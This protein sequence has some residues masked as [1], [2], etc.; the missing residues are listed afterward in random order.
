VVISGRPADP[1]ICRDAL[2]ASSCDL[3]FLP[4][5]TPGE[6]IGFAFASAEIL[7]CYDLDLGLRCV[8]G[9][10]DYVLA[11]G[12]CPQPG[13]RFDALLPL[14]GLSLPAPV[15]LR[16]A[17]AGFGGTTLLILDYDEHSM[18]GALDTWV[19]RLLD[20]P[21]EGSLPR[22]IP[23]PSMVAGQEYDLDLDLTNGTT[24]PVIVHGSFVYS[25]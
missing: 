15:C 8:D 19:D 23:L 11:A 13:T 6:G 18:R 17:A 3:G 16:R 4:D 14:A 25:G 5:G 1:W 7:P 12:P 24:P 22:R 9:L 10:I 21:F 2:E 20:S